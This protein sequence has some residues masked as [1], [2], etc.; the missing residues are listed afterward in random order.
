LDNLNEDAY[1]ARFIRNT[2]FRWVYIHLVNTSSYLFVLF[3][4]YLATS[5]VL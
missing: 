4:F 5:K 2:V 1:Q 3:L